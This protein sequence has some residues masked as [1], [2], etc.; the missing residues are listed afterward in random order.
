MKKTLFILFLLSATFSGMSQN[1]GDKYWNDAASAFTSS[2]DASGQASNN[3]AP[4]LMGG[5]VADA[6]NHKVT[7]SFTSVGTASYY[8]PFSFDY[9]IK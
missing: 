5:I 6:V 2:D 8:I 1:I 9:I 3:T 7:F 4:A